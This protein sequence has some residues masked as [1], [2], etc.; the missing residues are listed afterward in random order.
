M[1][2]FDL[3]GGPI[4]DVIFHEESISEVKNINFGRDRPLTGPG[5]RNLDHETGNNQYF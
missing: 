2:F 3:I 4:F 5:I 1:N